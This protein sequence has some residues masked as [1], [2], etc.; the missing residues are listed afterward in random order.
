MLGRLYRYKQFHEVQNGSLLIT[1]LIL[2]NIKPKL[3][4]RFKVSLTLFNL[5][6]TDFCLYMLSFVLMRCVIISY[7]YHNIEIQINE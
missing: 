3:I 7:Y 5:V 4:Y 6:L 2:C 1:A